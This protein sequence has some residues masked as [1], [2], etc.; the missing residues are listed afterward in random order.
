[1]ERYNREITRNLRQPE[2]F[3]GD[4][5]NAFDPFS[6]QNRFQGESEYHDISSYSS[7]F[8]GDENKREG[9]FDNTAQELEFE[10]FLE[11]Q[12]Y[13]LFKETRS[14]NGRNKEKVKSPV[15][16]K[17]SKK[18]NNE[19]KQLDSLMSCNPFNYKSS[20]KIIDVNKVRESLNFSK[21]NKF[22]AEKGK[23]KY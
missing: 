15:S 22:L 17:I 16:T 23:N 21:K 14:K 6:A 1:M 5:L 18:K 20:R 13:I 8:P 4:R 19:L 3:Y 10:E 12:E 9:V 11:N 2:K 7:N